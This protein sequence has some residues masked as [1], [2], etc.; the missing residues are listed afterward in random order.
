VYRRRHGNR[1]GYR[2]VALRITHHVLDGL[3]AHARDEAPFECCG[4]LA[5]A[6]DLIDEY[7][8]TRN[9]RASEVAYEID[10]REHISVMKSLRAQG[11]TVLGAYHSHPRTAALPSATDVAEAH[12]EQDF[13]YV[14]VSLGREPPDLRAYRL[15]GDRMIEAPFEALA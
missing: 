4:L 11:R 10:P 3:I 2:G 1:D 6:G 8:R 14:I 15:E 13:L 9:T 7:V 12:Y 5:G